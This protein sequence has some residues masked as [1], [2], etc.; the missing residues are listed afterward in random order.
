MF[1]QPERGHEMSRSVKIRKP[2]WTDPEDIKYLSFFGTLLQG[3]VMAEARVANTVFELRR[4]NVPT[5]FSVSNP[6]RRLL[7]AQCSQVHITPS[8]REALKSIASAAC[9]HSYEPKALPVPGEMVTIEM[10]KVSDGKMPVYVRR[11][12]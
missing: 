3:L 1:Q 5:T 11:Q 9:K 4:K 2:R 6:V 10:M 12:P 7:P 8:Q